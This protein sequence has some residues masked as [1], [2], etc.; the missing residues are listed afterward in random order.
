MEYRRLGRTGLSVSVLGVGC[1]YLQVVEYQEG[2]RLLERAIELGCSYFDG[3]YG[4]SNQKLRPLLK[5]RRDKL[6]VVTKTHETTADGALRRIDED[7]AEL[8]ADYIDVFLLRVA[9][10]DTLHQQLAPGGAFDG[11]L[12]A[13]EAGKIRCMGLSGHCGFPTLMEGMRSGLVDV[14]LMM[15][16]IVRREALDEFIPLAQRLDVGLAVMKPVSVGAI[17]ARVALPWLMNQPIHTMVPG[18]CTLAQLEEDV[19]AVERAT[20]ALSAEEEAEAEDWRRRLDRSTCRICDEHCGPE[21]ESKL[22]ISGTIHHDVWYNHYKNMGLE[23]FLA[24]PWA[25]WAK[26]TLEAHFTWRLQAISKCTWC[27]KCETACPYHLPVMDILRGMLADHPPLIE[28]LHRLGWAEQ[29]K[30][31]ESPYH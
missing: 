5:G 31:S 1:G 21:C 25:P 23:A 16:N 17:P 26:R 22:F 2:V 13:R 3:R 20:L 24:H 7:L 8:G 4:D 30:D 11:C 9:D 27:A 28:A 29:Y 12:K 10:R 18:M 19:A 15:M 6:V 14:V